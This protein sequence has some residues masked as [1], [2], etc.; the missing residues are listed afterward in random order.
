MIS[1]IMPY[2]NRQARLTDTLYSYSRF[3]AELDFE[4]IIVDDGSAEKPIIPPNL[5]FKVNLISLPEKKIALNPCAPLNRGAEASQGKVLVITNPE[6]EHTM[7]IFPAMQEELYLQGAHGYVAA[8]CWSADTKRW[9]CH[10]SIRN[11]LLG[12][13]PVPDRAGLHFCSMLF[14]DFFWFAG[15][16]DEDY[17]AGQGF[18]DNDFLWQLHLCEAQFVIRD[19]L[20]VNHYSTKTLWPAGGHNLNRRIF[21]QK[22]NGIIKND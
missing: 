13:A 4:V 7:P 19:D 8:G 18:E 9:Y 12:R 10:S 16:F 22:W 6:V 11:G 5:P 3:Y 20:V 21:E 2:W 17:R 1:V 15:G 14:K